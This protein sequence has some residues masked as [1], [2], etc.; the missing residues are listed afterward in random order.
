MSYCIHVYLLQYSTRCLAVVIT[1]LV[2]NWWTLLPM[3]VLLVGFLLI[4][5][6]FLKTG[7][8]VKRLEAVGE[9]STDLLGTIKYALV[10]AY[11]CVYDK[12]MPEVSI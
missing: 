6:Y 3:L 5:W 11:A 10:C 9:S 7:R 2:A 4:R 8:E 12:L 1:A